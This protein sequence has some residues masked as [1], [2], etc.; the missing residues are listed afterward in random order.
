MRALVVFLVVLS[1]LAVAAPARADTQERVLFREINAVREGNGL[2]PLRFG[3]RLAEYAERHAGRMIRAGRIFHSDVSFPKPPG[4]Q[5]AGE[6]VGVGP[7]L[8]AV[9][10]ALMASPEHRRNRLNPIYR[11]VGIGIKERN[12]RVWVAVEYVG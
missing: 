5:L 6:N 11:R 1:A 3:P 4:W 9:N 8:Y 2:E 12:G 7:T 10:D